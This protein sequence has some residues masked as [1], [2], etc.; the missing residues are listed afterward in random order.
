MEAEAGRAGQSWPPSLQDS[1]STL[2][3]AAASAPRFAA[4][5]QLPLLLTWP[6]PLRLNQH[7]HASLLRRRRQHQRRLRQAAIKI[8]KLCIIQHRCCQ[9]WGQL[10]WN[11]GLAGGVD[12]GA[13]AAWVEGRRGKPGTVAECLAAANP[14]GRQAGGR[15]GGQAG[16]GRTLSV[17]DDVSER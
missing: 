14:A 4:P 3:A 2:A 11:H 9:L 5:P 16:R 17:H 10:L 6:Q 1:P 13:G 12:A 7:R 8:N 15:A